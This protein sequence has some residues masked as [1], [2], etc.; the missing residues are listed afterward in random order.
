MASDH[1]YI[2]VGSQIH[3]QVFATIFLET[4][5]I[6]TWHWM[7]KSNLYSLPNQIATYLL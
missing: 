1:I 6:G 4:D 3:K 2:Q 5:M 7:L